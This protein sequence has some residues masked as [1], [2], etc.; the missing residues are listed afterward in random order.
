MRNYLG[1]L[2]LTR[3]ASQ[4]DV[5]TAIEMA[6][7]ETHDTQTLHDAEIVLCERVKRTYYERT[8][9]QYEAISAALKCL[10]SPGAK[11]THR[12]TDR[13]VEFEPPEEDDLL[14]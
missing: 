9:L 8:H 10:Q 2:S 7:R 11:D 4:A 6:L 14:W 12:W 3:K 13:L 1:R 5:E